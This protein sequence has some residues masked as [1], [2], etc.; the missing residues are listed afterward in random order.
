MRILAISVLATTITGGTWLPPATFTPDGSALSSTEFI[1]S[2]AAAE[3]RQESSWYK[4][5]QSCESRGIT[6]MEMNIAFTYD[7]RFNQAGR[8]TLFYLPVRPDGPLPGSF[9]ERI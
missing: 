5:K 6:L 9:N 8:W 2:A 3:W 1:A 4:S 7:C